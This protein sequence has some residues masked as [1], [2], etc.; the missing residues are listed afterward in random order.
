MHTTFLYLYPESE[1]N[2]P[3]SFIT[4]PHL[5]HNFF[6]ELKTIHFAKISIVQRSTFNSSNTIDE[7]GYHFICD[8]YKATLRW[9]QEP[10]VTFQ[11]LAELHPDVIHVRGLNLPLQFRWLRRI[12]GE[13]TILVGEHTGEDF[14]AQRNLWLQQFGLRVV[15][16]FIFGDLKDAQRWIKASVILEKQPIIEIPTLLK[17]PTQKADKIMNFYNK[18]TTTKNSKESKKE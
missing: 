18:L 10:E 8:E 13:S 9:W 12:V 4:L 14:W 1:F 3:E 2:D 7:I 17:N 16:G 11:K 5:P 6:N 15:D